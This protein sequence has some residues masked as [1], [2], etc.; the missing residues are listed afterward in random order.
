MPYQHITP[1]RGLPPSAR[2]GLAAAVAAFAL[3]ACGT[4]ATGQE[5]DAASE[6]AA[7]AGPNE[8]VDQSTA[9]RTKAEVGPVRAIRLATA[10][11]GGGRVFDMGLDRERGRLLWELDV[12]S[13]GKAYDVDLDARTGKV[14]RLKRD[15]TPDRGTRLLK[16]ANVRAA[17]AARTA[18]AAVEGADLR[19]LELDRWRGRVVWEAELTTANGTDHDVKVSARSGKVVSNKI[20][21]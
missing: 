1:A 4:A 11:V 19:A 7:S 18:T 9:G 8:T 5:R 14:V 13:A 10:A 2:T 6:P 15:R 21:D 20:D 12:A 3:A 17:K 16:V